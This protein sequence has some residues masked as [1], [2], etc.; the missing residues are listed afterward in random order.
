MLSLT[1]L[2]LL[3]EFVKRETSLNLSFSPYFHLTFGCFVKT[4]DIYIL[5]NLWMYIDKILPLLYD[6]MFISFIK[7]CVIGQNIDM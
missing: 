5:P 3:S 2:K 1:N 4:P 6:Y 7:P